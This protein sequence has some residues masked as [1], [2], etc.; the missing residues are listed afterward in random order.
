MKELDRVKAKKDVP[1]Q[2]VRAG[3]IGAI[4]H[5]TG[6]PPVYLV[7]FTREDGDPTDLVPFTAAEIDPAA[8]A[9]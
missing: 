9:A 6:E 8:P 1:E 4:L 7:E 2:G 3:M 5:V